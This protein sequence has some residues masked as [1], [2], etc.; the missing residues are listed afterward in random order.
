MIGTEI[1]WKDRVGLLTTPENLFL[2]RQ[3]RDDVFLTPL[4]ETSPPQHEAYPGDTLGKEPKKLIVAGIEPA[5]LC[6]LDIFM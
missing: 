5:I 4:G 3:K 1:S 6:D 2:A